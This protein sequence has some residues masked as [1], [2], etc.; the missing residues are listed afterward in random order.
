MKVCG[1]HPCGRPRRSGEQWLTTMIEQVLRRTTSPRVRRRRSGERVL[2]KTACVTKMVVVCICVGG[3]ACVCVQS[4]SDVLDRA[5]ASKSV[6][7]GSVCAKRGVCGADPLV[8]G[9]VVSGG[10]SGGRGDVDD[11]DTWV[12]LSRHRPGS[13]S[14]PTSGSGLLEDPPTCQ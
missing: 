3:M 8:C 12:P 9:R 10:C 7:V 11:C 5:Q 2:R 1:V 4:S 6:A 13:R 14:S